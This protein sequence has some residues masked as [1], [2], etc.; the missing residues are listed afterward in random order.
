MEILRALEEESGLRIGAQEEYLPRLSD[1]NG[2]L[3]RGRSTCLQA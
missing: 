2:I 3:S 1:C